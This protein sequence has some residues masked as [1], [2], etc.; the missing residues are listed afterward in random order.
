MKEL[1]LDWT[2]LGLIG[3]AS[4]LSG[5]RSRPR[6][7]LDRAGGQGRPVHTVAVGFFVPASC[8]RLTPAGPREVGSTRWK[9][10]QSK[11][12]RLATRS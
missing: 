2:A 10:K 11:A 6:L 12:A 9:S 5:G 1:L 7:V 8:A 4:G 3:L